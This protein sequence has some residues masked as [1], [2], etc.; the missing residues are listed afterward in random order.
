[1]SVL[2]AILR[3]A[4]EKRQHSV[5]MTCCDTCALIIET[6]ARAES[7]SGDSGS[8]GQ[9]NAKV[10]VLG[11]GRAAA[12]GSHMMIMELSTLLVSETDS[13]LKAIATAGSH[14]GSGAIRDNG[15]ERNDDS[16]V[17]TDVA[18]NMYADGLLAAQESACRLIRIISE[19]GGSNGAALVA[20]I[21]DDANYNNTLDPWTRMSREPWRAHA[22]D[23]V[24]TYNYSRTFFG[25]NL[26]WG[27][28]RKR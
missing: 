28:E 24:N 18:D 23:C 19:H 10:G 1:M 15:D 7:S 12:T 22:F 17:W 2:A 21:L 13:A 4:I 6:A 27:K 3:G 11:Q 8:E 25:E 9:P 5:A 20:K 26:D 14:A 16:S